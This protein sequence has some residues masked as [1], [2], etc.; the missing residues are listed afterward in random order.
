MSCGT[1]AAGLLL[2]HSTQLNLVTSTGRKY[3]RVSG[4]DGILLQVDVKE[5]TSQSIVINYS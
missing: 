4:G 1:S 5:V 3:T 2:E